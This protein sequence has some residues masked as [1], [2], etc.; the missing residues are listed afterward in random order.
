MS[1]EYGSMKKYFRV[2][3]CFHGCKATKIFEKNEN[4]HEIIEHIT[5]KAKEVILKE[6]RMNDSNITKK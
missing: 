4:K 6:F 1:K 5:R 3:E 2:I